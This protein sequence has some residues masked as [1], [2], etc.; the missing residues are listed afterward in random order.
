M[1]VVF[2]WLGVFVGGWQKVEA[3]QRKVRIYVRRYDMIISNGKACST[4]AQPGASFKTG[5]EVCAAVP[6]ESCLQKEACLSI[7]RPWRELGSELKVKQVW[8][9]CRSSRA[10]RM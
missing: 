9:G 1:F 10:E 4:D 3:E 6:N 7:T 2:S 5:G 8:Q